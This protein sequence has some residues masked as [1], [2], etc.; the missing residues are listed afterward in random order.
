MTHSGW[1]ADI[2][3][4]RG[5]PAFSF[6]SEFRRLAEGVIEK[7]SDPM[8]MI[9]FEQPKSPWGSVARLGEERH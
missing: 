7:E 9:K 8:T 1:L 2:L 4:A 5:K 6:G 3:S